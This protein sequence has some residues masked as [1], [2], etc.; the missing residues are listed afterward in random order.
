MDSA[1]DGIRHNTGERIDLQRVKDPE[2]RP[3]RHLLRDFTEFFTAL[4]KGGAVVFPKKVHLALG[5]DC[6]DARKFPISCGV[7]GY[8]RAAP[9]DHFLI[10]AHGIAQTVGGA[11]SSSSRRPE[12]GKPA[13]FKAGTRG[14]QSGV[15]LT[16]RRSGGRKR[17]AVY[18]FKER[19]G[20]GDPPGQTPGAL[21]RRAGPSGE[22]PVL[23][24]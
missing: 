19:P 6:A 20:G 10:V 4:G 7:L 12:R 18:G 23:R 1:D 2:I 16:V 13:L 9:V 5:L 21:V 8:K 24:R 14:D 11:L 3:G 22:G 15:A 17:S